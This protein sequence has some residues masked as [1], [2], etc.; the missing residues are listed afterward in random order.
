MAEKIE[1]AWSKIK[2]SWQ[3]SVFTWE[4]QSEE[5]GLELLSHLWLSLFED[6]SVFRWQW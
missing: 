2:Y 6:A 3:I 5:A 4:T 1:Y